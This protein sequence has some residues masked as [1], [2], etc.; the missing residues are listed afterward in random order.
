MVELLNDKVY[1][2][3]T[4]MTENHQ[5][6]VHLAGKGITGITSTDYNQS[7]K[8]TAA[9]S[10][11]ELQHWKIKQAADILF[12]NAITSTTGSLGVILV[13][14]FTLYFQPV[15]KP[16]L[17]IWTL[18]ATTIAIAR[19][20]LWWGYT[21]HFSTRS[22]EFWL[23]GYRLM[24]MASGILNGVSPW[25]FF[26]QVSPP[27]QLLILFSIAGLT[28]AATGTH[29]V[30]TFTFKSFLYCACIP[31]IIKILLLGGP[32]Y[33]ALCLMLVFYILVMGRTGRHNYATLHDNLELTYKMQYRATHDVLVDLL[34]REE[35]EN[36]FES[37]LYRTKH[38]VAILFID[39]DNFKQLNDVIGHHAGDEALVQVADIIQQSIRSDDIS[40]RLGGDE[41][42]VSLLLNDSQEAEKI[43]SKILA[44][45]RALNFPSECN[46]D[47]LSA[48]IGI[49]FHHNNQ[50]GFSHL[51]RTADI[52]CY[53]SKERGKNQI[54]LRHAKS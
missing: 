49:A 25:L 46:Y 6:L 36:Q 30:D 14:A 41:F 42:V 10:S 39:L 1:K 22:F 43:A 23:N 5:V 48:S 2:L 20:L 17:I 35:F 26:E 53:E 4:G 54:V 13:L 7:M 8:T 19:I 21:N 29:A 12:S 52:A 38:G 11:K 44:G 50:V 28:A 34:N 3:V 51:M 18:A 33:Y 16:I 15:E 32:T 9:V 27:H 40:A 37:R 24:T 47:G 45:V 31:A